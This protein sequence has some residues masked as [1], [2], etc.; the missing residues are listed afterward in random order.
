MEV[1]GSEGANYYSTMRSSNLRLA[2]R[3]GLKTTISQP[4]DRAKHAQ[5]MAILQRRK[6]V[7]SDVHTNIQIPECGIP[8]RL[9]KPT[10]RTDQ[11]LRRALC[12][13]V[14]FHNLGARS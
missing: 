12:P 10:W 14:E 5:K 8:K 6:Q 9:P 4:N 1:W 7:V 3:A 13:I 2:R 11:D